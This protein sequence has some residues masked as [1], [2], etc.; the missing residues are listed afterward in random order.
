MVIF[1]TGHPRASHF[2]QRKK[3]SYLDQ[4]T[5]VIK[6]GSVKLKL[7][8]LCSAL[9]H[10]IFM[11]H[12]RVL[13]NIITIAYD[14]FKSF[15]TKMINIYY[16]IVHGKCAHFVKISCS[17]DFGGFCFQSVM[18]LRLNCKFLKTSQFL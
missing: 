10:P 5:T 11:K 8:F 3:K 18:S 13:I 15:I 6:V 9:G 12:R 7:L 1:Y 4:G 14:Q 2:T 17:V 16:K